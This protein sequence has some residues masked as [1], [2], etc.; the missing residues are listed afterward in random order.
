MNKRKLVIA[1]LAPLFVSTAIADEAYEAQEWGRE[2]PYTAVTYIYDTSTGI[3]S[4]GYQAKVSYSTSGEKRIYISA[5]RKNES[6]CKVND[7]ADTAVITVN[8]QPIKIYQWCLQYTDSDK[9]YLNM[10]AVTQKGDDYIERA[11]ITT[12]DEVKIEYNSDFFGISAVGFTR[13]WN[14]MKGEA[15]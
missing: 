11:F 7:L 10:A 5:I 15:L 12:K 4:R 13:I 8:G 2:S 14:S 9:Y 6:A 3:A 1:L